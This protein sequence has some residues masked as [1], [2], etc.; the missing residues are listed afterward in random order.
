MMEWKGREG[1]CEFELGWVGLDG[2][3]ELRVVRE[4]GFGLVWWDGR[5][6]ILIFG[7]KEEEEKSVP[8]IL[9]GE[10]EKRRGGRDICWEVDDAGKMEWEFLLIFSFFCVCVGVWVCVWVC[11]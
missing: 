1:L 11:V 2:V 5:R 4:V 7:K 3:Q 10:L 6:H 9:K 8:V